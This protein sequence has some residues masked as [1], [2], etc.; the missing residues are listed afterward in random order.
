MWLG[1][2]AKKK[3]SVPL[4]N[5]ASAGVDGERLLMMAHLFEF[6]F[7]V[8][9][10]GKPRKPHAIG[11][12]LQYA[13][14]AFSLKQ[15]LSQ[16]GFPHENW[17]AVMAGFWEKLKFWLE[18]GADPHKKIGLTGSTFKMAERTASDDLIMLLKNAYNRRANTMVR[19]ETLETRKFWDTFSTNWNINF[20]FSPEFRK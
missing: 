1:Y 2:G 6:G 4:H 5:A 17:T 14:K 11:A 13:T 18:Q 9:E 3:N 12:L 7:D 10:F 8:N 20:S 16:T 15:I 19:K